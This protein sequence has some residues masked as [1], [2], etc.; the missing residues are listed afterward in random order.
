M[1]SFTNDYT[2]HSKVYYMA[3]KSESLKMFKRYQATVVGESGERIRRL[4]SDRGS[5]YMGDE[6]EQYLVDQQI[7]HEVSCSHTP[8]ENGF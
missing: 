1:I 3:H 6:F 2:R 5:E 8:E 4:M 7:K